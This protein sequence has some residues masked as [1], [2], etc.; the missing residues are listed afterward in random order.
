[1]NNKRERISATGHSAVIRATGHIGPHFKL[2]L[3]GH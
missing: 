2:I 3:K 1:M